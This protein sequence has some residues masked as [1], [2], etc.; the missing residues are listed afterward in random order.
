MLSSQKQVRYTRQKS[1]H[2]KIYSY[3]GR[4]ISKS[5]NVS[6]VKL[7]PLSGQTNGPC[8]T[9]FVVSTCLES[10]NGKCLSGVSGKPTSEVHRQFYNP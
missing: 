5:I 10:T 2:H 8:Q 6:P 9:S 7:W 3:L 4:E 1:H